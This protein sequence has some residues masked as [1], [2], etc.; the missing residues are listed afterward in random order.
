M[1]KFEKNMSNIWDRPFMHRKDVSYC[2]RLLYSYLLTCSLSNIAGVFLI[3]NSR[4]MFDTALKKQELSEAWRELRRGK[5][6]FR[7]GSYV[8]IKDAPFFLPKKTKTEERRFRSILNALP[9]KVKEKL[10]KIGYFSYMEVRGFV[11]DEKDVKEKKR[12]VMKRRN[13]DFEAGVGAP[14][15]RR[16]SEMASLDKQK[17]DAVDLGKGAPTGSSMETS[18]SKKT[19]LEAFNGSDGVSTENRGGSET[20][21]TERLS[22]TEPY[23]VIDDSE[24]GSVLIEEKGGSA[25]DEGGLADVNSLKEAFCN[26]MERKVERERKAMIDKALAPMDEGATAGLK[27]GLEEESPLAGKSSPPPFS[28]EVGAGVGAPSKN[29]S[30]KAPQDLG[31]P[32]EAG[33]SL[34]KEQVPKSR[35]QEGMK[36]EAPIGLGQEAKAGSKEGALST[37]KPFG[38]PQ[39]LGAQKV[40][41]APQTSQDLGAPQNSEESRVSQ[42]LETPRAPQKKHKDPVAEYLDKLMERLNKEEEEEERQAAKVA[43]D[44]SKKTPNPTVDPAFP[45]GAFYEVDEDYDIDTRLRR[46]ERNE[47]KGFGYLEL[48]AF[49]V[50]FQFKELGFYSVLDF[51]AFFKSEFQK[52][53]KT[54]KENGINFKCYDDG[55][56]LFKALKHYLRVM[57]MQKDGITWWHSRLDFSHFCKSGWNVF[58]KDFSIAKF[59]KT[60][61]QMS[62]KEL[63]MYKKWKKQGKLRENW[64]N[65]YLAV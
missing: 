59:T 4:I 50:F 3:S 23:W 38:S 35:L 64:Y 29:P 9:L 40:L 30:S 34:E 58:T 21:D 26:V 62:E 31:A 25:D 7:V 32:V 45:F 17:E 36:E 11:L 65:Y 5:K 15:N 42:D 54:L 41:E 57:E 8:I 51:D 18:A 19:V 20:S 16:E 47:A 24:M 1:F 28:A 52:G 49:E 53:L 61:A 48:I 60:M 43:V 27:V 10:E 13:E 44:Y 33:S 14:S 56:V 63:V 6:V 55:E 39:D 46:K 2:G 37:C 22:P 12:R